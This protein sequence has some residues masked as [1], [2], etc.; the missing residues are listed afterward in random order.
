M[1]RELGEPGEDAPRPSVAFFGQ[2]RYPAPLDGDQ[3][4]FA[5][6]EEGVDEK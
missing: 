1:K 4:E 5:R 2:T 3:C 6:D